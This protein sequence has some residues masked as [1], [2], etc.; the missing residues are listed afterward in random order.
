MLY[1]CLGLLVA[2]WVCWLYCLFVVYIVCCD[3]CFFALTWLWFIGVALTVW[4]CVSF[5]FVFV[6][7]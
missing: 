6:L 5:G 1:C 3:C 7:R 4:F 2:C